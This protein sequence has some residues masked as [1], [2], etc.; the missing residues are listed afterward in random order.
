MNILKLICK[1]NVLA[2]VIDFDLVLEGDFLV[3][4]FDA[5]YHMNVNLFATH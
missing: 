5:S 2:S 3:L 1:K 4:K